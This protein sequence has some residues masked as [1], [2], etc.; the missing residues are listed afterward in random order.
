MER[1]SVS[2]ECR[3]S[4]SNHRGNEMPSHFMSSSVRSEPHGANV[5]T[6]GAGERPHASNESA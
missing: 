5:S 2:A 4:F 3:S 6:T 1:S